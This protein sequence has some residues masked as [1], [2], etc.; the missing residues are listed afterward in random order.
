MSWSQDRDG[1]GKFNIC[2]I[3]PNL[4][5]HVIYAFSE[6][7]DSNRLTFSESNQLN[8]F[9]ALLRR[10]S[11]TKSLVSL[12]GWDSEPV[13]LNRLTRKLFLNNVIGLL[14]KYDLDG[15]D[16]DWEYPKRNEWDHMTGWV[17]EIAERLHEEGFIVSALVS[18]SSR[19]ASKSY[20]IREISRS[21][22]FVNLMTFDF[23]GYYENRTGL[24]SAARSGREDFDLE[25]NVVS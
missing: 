21:L 4:C 24:H 20:N 18:A 11:N 7:L 19:Q 12:V 23:H 25:A 13:V 8:D 17:R 3:D 14:K 15:V 22:D 5:T 9:S 6:V 10:Y 16:L 2:H 1:D